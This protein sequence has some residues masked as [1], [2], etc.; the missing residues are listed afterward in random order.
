MLPISFAFAD[1]T[2]AKDMD[3][4][5]SRSSYILGTNY[6]IDL[7]NVLVVQQK[8]IKMPWYNTTTDKLLEPA[9]IIEELKTWDWSDDEKANIALLLL[10]WGSGETSITRIGTHEVPFLSPE[11][12]LVFEWIRPGNNILKYIRCADITKQSMLLIGV[13]GPC[14]GYLAV[15]LPG[16]LRCIRGAL[17]LGG[18]GRMTINLVLRAKEL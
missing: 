7:R 3:E 4:F 17:R 8:A 5:A 2:A 13:A 16:V 1:T 11:K 9:G 18:G 15:A 12:E 10:A 6:D 14:L